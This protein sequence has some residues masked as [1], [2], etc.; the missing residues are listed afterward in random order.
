[1]GLRFDGTVLAVGRNNHGQGDVGNWMN[2]TQVAA[3][4]S[5]TVGLKSDGTVIAVGANNDGQCDVGDWDL[6]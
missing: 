6:N 5:F 4:W 1:V 3:G 2:I